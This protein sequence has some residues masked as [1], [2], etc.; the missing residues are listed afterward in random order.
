MALDL[1]RRGFAAH[2]LGVEADP[3]AAEA[4]KTIGLVDEV[5]DLDTCI[6]KA[7]I[8]VLAVPVGTAVKL[9]THVLDQVQKG[10][11]VSPEAEKMADASVETPAPFWTWSR[12]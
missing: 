7:D 4:A 1:K 9:V 5:V 11:G 12:T 10:A 2:T 3:V 8:V 6:Q